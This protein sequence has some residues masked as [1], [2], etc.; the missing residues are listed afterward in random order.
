M[1]HDNHFRQ[2]TE[3]NFHLTKFH[4]SL[5]TS[6]SNFAH[7]NFQLDLQWTYNIINTTL[8]TYFMKIT[9]WIPKYSHIIVK[10][11]TCICIKFLFFKY[12][13]CITLY[14]SLQ[15]IPTY[16]THTYIIYLVISSHHKHHKRQITGTSHVI[17]LNLL[18]NLTYK[19]YIEISIHVR[20]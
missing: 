6:T 10:F 2:F 11:C 20:Y 19:I 3:L 1:L 15:Y 14:L 16:T 7:S 4:T 9:N 12:I 18:Y 5:F 13:V 8:T 17:T